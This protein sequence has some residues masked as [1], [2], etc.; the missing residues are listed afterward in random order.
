MP[1]E[2]DRY[3]RLIEELRRGRPTRRQILKG[4]LAGGALL[5]TSSLPLIGAAQTPKRGGTMRVAF[6]GT[7]SKLD[8]HQMTGVEEVAIGRS[9]YDSLVFTDHELIARPE[10][11]T[12]W[13]SSP[14]AKVWT[15][16]LRKGVKFHHGREMDAEDVVWSYK[17]IL[18]PA[19]ASPARSVFSNVKEIVKLDPSTVRFTLADPFAEFPV[20]VGGSFQARIAPRDVPDLGKTPIGTGPFKLTDYV[21]G[22][23]ATMM[24]NGDYWR[25]GQPYLDQLRFLFLP[26]EASHVAG[27]MSGNLEMSW[28][29]LPE[30]LPIYRTN[31]DIVIQVTPTNGYQPIVMGVDKPPF[32]DPR[33]RRAMRLLCDRNAMNKI[34]L[35]ELN[36]APSNDHPI[37]PSSPM[38]MTQ[39]VMQQN[40]DEAKKLLADAGYANGMDVELM[41]WTGRA[42]LIQEALAF[43]DMA[44]KANVRISVNTVP[45]DVF[46]SKYWPGKH[47]FFVTNWSARTTLYELIAIAYASDAKW[48]ESH[49]HSPKL[50]G[51][52]GQIR[53]EQDEAKRKAIF[54]DVQKMFLDDGP[55]IVSYHRP[56]VTA[57]RSNVKGFQP[58]PSAWVDVRTVWLS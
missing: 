23:H 2:R 30:V 5:A 25:D 33:V 40:V 15:F 52:I 54:A 1:N 43:Q 11:A 13:E 7:P 16:H 24:R 53:S 32:N 37:P 44:K 26:E 50:D 48:N 12:S 51:L 20:L 34:V 38:Y 9:V 42:G 45:S 22:D 29:P 18:D 41:A 31:K 19:T 28:S 4:G 27:L 8:I 17:R 55:V 46:L 47:N 10:L 57:T 56:R 21:A 36:V 6:V 35:G 49:W 14:D 58:H 3:A 39:N